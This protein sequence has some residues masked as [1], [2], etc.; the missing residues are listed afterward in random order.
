MDWAVNVHGDVGEALQLCVFGVSLVGSAW[1]LDAAGGSGLLGYLFAGLLLGPQVLDF[2][3]QIDSIRVLGRIGVAFLLLEAGLH[4]D[5]AIVRQLGLR[6]F[7]L[8]LAGMTTPLLGGMVVMYVLGYTDLLQAFGVGACF[9]PTSVG[10]SVQI[11]ADFNELDTLSGQVSNLTHASIL[12]HRLA[13]M[14]IL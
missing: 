11:L 1:L 13:A 10:M 6:A 2:V 3:P 7:G 14:K 9:M 12:G 8:T 4:I 5:K